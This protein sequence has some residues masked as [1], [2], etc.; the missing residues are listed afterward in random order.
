MKF[1]NG[2]FKSLILLAMIALSVFACE[3]N[4]KNPTVK[5]P[6]IQ[7]TSV[8]NQSTETEGVESRSNASELRDQL[9]ALDHSSYMSAF[10][11]LTSIQKYE[12]WLDKFDAVLEHDWN[13]EQLYAIQSWNAALSPELFEVGFTD[14]EDQAYREDLLN[15]FTEEQVQ[16]IFCNLYDLDDDIQFAAVPNGDSD[17][18]CKY[19]LGCGF[20]GYCDYDL[21]CDDVYGCGIL[22]GAM[23][24]GLC[25]DPIYN[26]VY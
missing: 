14:D 22:G 20:T 16:R 13:D 17:C 15:Y 2:A 11:Q 18:K 24:K 10:Q 26:P 23:C 6:N 21:E 1:T 19:N 7:T 8:Q 3:E 12:L 5:V 25:D 9:T 4:V